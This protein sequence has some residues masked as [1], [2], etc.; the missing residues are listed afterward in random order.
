LNQATGA[1]LIGRDRLELSGF[2]GLAV[3]PGDL[4][5]V[6]GT[7]AQ[8]AIEDPD[9]AVPQGPQGGVMGEVTVSAQGVVVP[10]PRIA[11]L[12]S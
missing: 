10:P 6:E 11:E 7:V 5:V 9:K 2:F 4:L 1:W 3:P 8:A 12:E